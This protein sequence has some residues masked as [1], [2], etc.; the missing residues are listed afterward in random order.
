MPDA[1]SHDSFKTYEVH[2]F[3]TEAFLYGG[4]FRGGKG[5]N[6]DNGLSINV[7]L[8]GAVHIHSGTFDG[9]IEVGDSSTI[10]FYGCFLQNGTIVSGEFADETTLSV[11]VRSRNGGEIVLVSV[12]EQE[13]ETAP[14]MSPTNFPTLSPQPTVPRPNA[15]GKVDVTYYGW[16]VAVI[17]L[18][19]FAVGE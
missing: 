9:D 14:S 19:Q 11:N 6:N 12:A 4:N 5:S 17:A 15:A 10:A 2:G 18:V 7:L 8:G 16:I 1:Y 13:C 3:G